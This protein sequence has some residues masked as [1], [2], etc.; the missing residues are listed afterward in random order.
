MKEKQ[1]TETLFYK[2]TQYIYYFFS[3]NALFL[4]CNTLFFLT[5]WSIPL[6]ISNIIIFAASLIPAGASITSL[7][8]TMG[9]LNRDKTISPFKDFFNSYKVNFR[10]STQYWG[11]FLVVSV[12]L[13]VDI[14]FVLQRGWLVLTVI[15]I[16]LYTVVI[17]SAIY[18]FS[19]L[20]RFEVSLKHLVIFSV[21][22]TFRY[23]RITFSHLCYA[24]AF[25]MIMF[26]FF[27]FAVLF[28]FSVA[29]FYFMRSN[30]GILEEL[31]HEF[32]REREEFNV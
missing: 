5:V 8:Y 26:G 24:F 22:L 18:A 17:L 6:S 2:I 4:L 7:F 32:S 3:L 12:I 27:R 21:Y 31:K 10:Q 23:K 14:L 25:S 20:S 19:L 29:A 15:S 1:S 16:I 13:I 28:I 11:L 30:E 9:K